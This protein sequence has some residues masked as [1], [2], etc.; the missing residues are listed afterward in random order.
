MWKYENIK[1]VMKT[2][3][4][5]EDS[6]LLIK[7]ITKTIENKIKEQRTGFLGMS[8]GTLSSVLLGDIL[9]AKL[10]SELV[11]KQLD[12]DRIFNAASSIN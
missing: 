9:Q 10:L 3:N 5:L 6:C 1:D 12:Q 7:N 4:S 8:L 2:F 11:E